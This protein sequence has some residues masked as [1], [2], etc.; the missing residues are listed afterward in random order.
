MVTCAI[1]G[2]SKGL[3]LELCRQL[4]A[5]GD[6]V[7]ALVRSGNDK[8]A[9]LGDKVKVVEG[10]DVTK[11]DVSEKLK[12]ALEGVSIDILIC[13][14][15][16]YG[17][18]NADGPMAMFA[19]QKLEAVS[20]DVMRE[21][22]ELNTLG[23]L[24]LVKALLP[25]IPRAGSSKIVIT[26]SLMGSIEDNTSGGSYAYRTAKAGVNM[27]GK[28]LAKDL[29]DEGI[30]VLLLHPGI[31]KTDFAGDHDKMPEGIRNSMHEVGP[32][33]V[34]MLQ[35]IDDVSIATTGSFIHGNYGEGTKPCPW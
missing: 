27:V 1:S 6:T 10:I 9:E 19:S 8:L 20:M 13:N 5:R 33:V 7:Y 35:A 2:A 16:A 4:A 23:P 17:G 29:K 34:G 24:R 14:A 18:S 26:T 11:D 3:G 32:S 30:A 28:S 15:G 31:V 25:Q 21:A 22:F 12:A